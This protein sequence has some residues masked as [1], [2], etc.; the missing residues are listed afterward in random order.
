MKLKL[1]NLFFFTLV[2]IYCFAQNEPFK[3]QGKIYSGLNKVSDVHIINL[4][5][6][7]GT[8]SN[9]YGDFEIT[10]KLND[11]ILFS[12]IEFEPK[13]IKVTENMVKSKNITVFLITSV[14][15]LKEVFVGLTGNLS[16]DLKNKPKDTIPK[17]TFSFT[18]ADLKKDLGPDIH[19]PKSAPFVGPFKPLPALATIPNFA[20]EKEQ[21]LKREIAK[22]KEFPI[23][24]RR[25]LGIKFFTEKLNIPEEKIDN[26]INYCE[27]RDVIKKYYE[28]KLFE[29]IEIFKEESISY[30]QIKE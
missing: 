4:N 27:Y 15:K 14:N 25:E 19:G 18:K 29:V 26:F 8:V 1:T 17:H 7:V 13:K 10:A 3:L 11:S 28:K 9:D 5:T 6:Y 2:T 21:R 24:I 20:Y 30:K 23:K 12:S 22:L 16:F